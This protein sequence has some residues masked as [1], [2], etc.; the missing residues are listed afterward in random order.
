MPSGSQGAAA[1]AAAA[2]MPGATTTSPPTKQPGT[3]TTTTTPRPFIDPETH[4][5]AWDQFT[6][7]GFTSP[8]LCTECAGS[9]PRKWDKR[10]GTGQSGATLVYNGDGLASFPAKIQL[11]WGIGGKTLAEEWADWYAFKELLKPPTTKNPQAL[12]IYHPNLEALPVPI[13]DVVVA[14]D[15]VI[16]PKQVGDGL[17][18][19]EI[20]FCQ[21][22]PAKPATAKAKGSGTTQ[23][24]PVD[25]LIKDLTS[26]VK[27][28]AK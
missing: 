14:D 12:S 15:G 25:Q 23:E 9:N 5:E 11:G 19:I 22:R 7:N 21:Y 16:G 28:L 6:L 4:P 1:G 27:D 8:G 2:L 24:D 17:W 20:K 18:E 10:D 26:Q 3:T 13:H